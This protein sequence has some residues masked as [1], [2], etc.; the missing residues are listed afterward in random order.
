MT[1]VQLPLP[2]RHPHDCSRCVYRGSVVVGAV[3]KDFYTCPSGW[4]DTD[5]VCRLSSEPA[6]VIQAPAHLAGASP[7]IDEA[8][9]LGVL[10]PTTKE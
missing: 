2:Q 7:F 6:D 4:A 9:H 10:L 1:L 3:Q 5:V 8:I